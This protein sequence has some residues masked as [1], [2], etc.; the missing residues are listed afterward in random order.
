[1]P[2]DPE[3]ATLHVEG[4]AG[5]EMQRLRGVVAEQRAA[6]VAFH[7]HEPAVVELSGSRPNTRKELLPSTWPT[8]R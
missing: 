6:S 4:V 8:Q 3:S 2:R 1:M 5:R 7:D